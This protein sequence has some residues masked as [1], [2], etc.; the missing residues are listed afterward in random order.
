MLRDYQQNAFDDIKTF[1]RFR[2]GNGIAVLPCG[3]GKSH[4]IAAVAEWVAGHK[5]CRVLILANRKEL[6]QQNAAK[7][8]NP[9][10]IGFVSAGI[11]K[12]EY[13]K[14]IIIAGIQTCFNKVEKLG[15]FKIIIVDECD[16]ISNNKKDN[17]IY[18]QL[19]NNYSETRII[20]FTAT[21][22]RTEDGAI[23]WGTICHVTNYLPLFEA[24]YLCTLTN[25]VPV[26]PDLSS[27][28]VVMG[29]YVI[30][31]AASA[32]LDEEVLEESVRK[33][34]HYGKN[35]NLWLVFASSVEHAHILWGMLHSNGIF[36]SILT[37][38]T[39]QAERE[40]I[41]DNCNNRIIKC[42]INVNIATVGVDIPL[43]DLIA[44]MRPTKSRR[45][46]EQ[47]LG[48]GTRLNDFKQN[49]LILDFAGNLKEHGALGD[50]SW[51]FEKGEIINSQKS[52]YKVCPE[53]EDLVAIRV[54]HCPNCTYHFAPEEKKIE[55]SS[56]IDTYSAVIGGNEIDGR[57]YNVSDI[58]YRPYISKKGN[59]VL[60]VEYMCGVYMKVYEFL[61]LNNDSTSW[62]YRTKVRPWLMETLPA[63]WHKIE[64]SEDKIVE[65]LKYKSH[66]KSPKKI[67]VDKKASSFTEIKEKRYD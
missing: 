13:D 32:M 21:P 6:L 34:L 44:I 66:A 55:I 38:D 22:Y 9:D 27:V 62:L 42:L 5:D 26:E 63:H 43:I 17:S 15:E 11:G 36:C 30:S 59:K 8:S 46:H 58:F 29:D 28:K 48:R 39:Q 31:Q 37:G 10:I 14:Q 65:F 24:G 1:L 41:I 61:A 57:W 3:S 53:C 67:L 4:L 51:R 2:T 33:L 40:K 64:S 25:K 49:T 35:R 54:S 7:F 19:L 12:Y 16:S 52:D 20:G 47:M 23:T 18:W 56:E 50:N 60:K 45:L